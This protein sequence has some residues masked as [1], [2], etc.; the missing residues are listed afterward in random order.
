MW[1]C[2]VST[3]SGYRGGGGV[4]DRR[5]YSTRERAAMLDARRISATVTQLRGHWLPSNR[6]R[7]GQT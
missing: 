5:L 6:P 3:N 4:S 7:S 2:Y 1:A